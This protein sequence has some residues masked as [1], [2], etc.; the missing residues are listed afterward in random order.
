MYAT[1]LWSLNLFTHSLSIVYILMYIF[2][3]SFS[4]SALH[5]SLLPTLLFIEIK[6]TYYM[7]H[8]NRVVQWL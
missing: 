2:S 7:T 3:L 6:F 1:S 4:L 8:L 5:L